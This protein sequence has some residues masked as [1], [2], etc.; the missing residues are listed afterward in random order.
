MRPAK[1]LRGMQNSVPKINTGKCLLTVGTDVKNV[2]EER[3]TEGRETEGRGGKEGT[4][5]G[6]LCG[7]NR[8][9]YN[10]VHYSTVQYSNRQNVELTFCSKNA[11]NHL[12]K[13]LFGALPK[14]S[15]WIQKY[16]QIC[17]VLKNGIK[18]D[19]SLIND[20]VIDV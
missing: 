10:T 15:N 8:V 9:Q 17:L 13:P 5:L 11:K 3:G 2:T 18:N 19:S 6:F 20:R 12:F 1:I 14:I 7:Y 16:V 4:R